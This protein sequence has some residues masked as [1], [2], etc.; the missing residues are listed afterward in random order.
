[1]FVKDNYKSFKVSHLS[2]LI[3]QRPKIFSG[4][5]GVCKKYRLLVHYKV[6]VK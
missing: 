5:G 6:I 4:G 2:I 1:M 3:I